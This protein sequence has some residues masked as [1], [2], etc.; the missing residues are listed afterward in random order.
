VER[1]RHS[2]PTWL[3]LL[4]LVLVATFVT[5]LSSAMRARV[6]ELVETDGTVGQAGYVY[7]S[8]ARG[9]RLMIWHD[10]AEVALNTEVS[11]SQQPAR[12]LSGRAMAGGQPLFDWEIE[13]PDGQTARF[14]IDGTA[15][16]LS[17]GT[18]FLVRS[19]GRQIEVEQLQRDLSST[20]PDPETVALFAASD[21]I[22]SDLARGITYR[23][24]R[25]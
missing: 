3:S 12:W 7:Y 14:R 6:R 4:L 23:E 18:V 16:D 17:Q 2:P 24:A 21:A 20:Q 11:G 8:S 15:Y 13:T 9:L 25:Y 5:F 19:E 10:A 22:L 1:D